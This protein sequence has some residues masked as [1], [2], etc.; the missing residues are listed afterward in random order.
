MGRHYNLD[1]EL[2]YNVDVLQKLGTSYSIHGW[3]ICHDDVKINV[4]DADRRPLDAQINRIA[5]RDVNQVYGLNEAYE[6]GFLIFI[7]EKKCTTDKLF[8][9]F[10]SKCCTKR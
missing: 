6:S 5:R 2:V 1:K 3:V 9:H 8:V 10:E 4:F 7:E